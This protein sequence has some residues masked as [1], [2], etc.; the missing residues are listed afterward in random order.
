MLK[1]EKSN[2]VRTIDMVTLRMGPFFTITLRWNFYPS[3][4][5]L[6]VTKGVERN[7]NK[8]INGEYVYIYP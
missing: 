2:D 6:H 1:V 8:K 5:C 4:L 7:K 3:L